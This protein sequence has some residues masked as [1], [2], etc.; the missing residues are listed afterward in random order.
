MPFEFEGACIRVAQNAPE[1]DDS[2]E[3]NIAR[4]KCFRNE[5]CHSAST[6]ATISSCLQALELYAYRHKTERLESDPIDHDIE[7]RVKEQ[8]DHWEQMDNE[9][10]LLETKRGS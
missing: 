2:L 3:A 8:V 10:T 1:D 6:E 5:L 4:I 7:R 9:L